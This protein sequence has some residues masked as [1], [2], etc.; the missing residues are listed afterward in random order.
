M[1]LA[2]LNLKKKE[3]KINSIINKI[4]KIHLSYCNIIFPRIFLY[5]LIKEYNFITINYSSWKDD[6][7][8]HQ[9][10]FE[11]IAFQSKI[12]EYLRRK[13]KTLLLRSVK[14]VPFHRV[15][16]VAHKPTNDESQN[17]HE[18]PAQSFHGLELVWLVGAVARSVER[19]RR[20]SALPR[21]SMY[22]SS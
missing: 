2:V 4:F 18:F 6:I 11:K 12:T 19:F 7:I 21:V 20:W 16:V 15:L 1:E 17:F 9:L 3:K 5:Y 22:V 13:S 8:L 10:N 14:A